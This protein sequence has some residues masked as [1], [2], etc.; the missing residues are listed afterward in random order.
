MA[1]II[2]EIS[3][4]LIIFFMV[5]YTIKC[6]TVLKPV[7]EDKKNHALNV[8]IVYVFYLLQMIVSI[9]YMVSYHGIYKKS[10]RLI[11]NNMSFL[12]LIGYVMLTRLDFDLAKKQFAFATITLVITAFIPL[13]IMKCKNLKNW[14]IFYAILGIGFLIT[15]FVPFLG[16]SK[17]GS[18]LSGKRFKQSK[19]I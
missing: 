1:T 19:G 12:L 4:Y 15:V 14:D 2:T 9:V 5:L 3:K 11:T 6:F 17:Y 7:R 18:I 10:S 8:Q 16:V 13:V